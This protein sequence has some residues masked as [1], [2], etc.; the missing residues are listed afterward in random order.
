MDELEDIL[1]SEISQSQKK[2]NAI[3]SYVYDIPRIVK[4]IETQ[5][6]M[7][8]PTSQGTGNKRLLN[9]Y[10]VSIW[11]DERVLEMEGPDGCT[12]V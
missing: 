6:R 2:T 4:F 3:Q 9:R 8:I 7:V 11:K 1:L 5:G 10:K 12:I